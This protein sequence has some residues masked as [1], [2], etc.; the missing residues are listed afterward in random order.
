MKR[1]VSVFLSIIS[2]ICLSFAFTGCENNEAD[3][4]NEVKARIFS[5]DIAY[6]WGWLDEDDLKSIACRQNECYGMDE[7]PYAGAF[8]QSTQMPTKAEKDFKK[9]YCEKYNSNTDKEPISADDVEI[10]YYYGTYGD[11]V[12]VEFNY[13]GLYTGRRIGGIKFSDYHYRAIYVLHYDE[14]RSEDLDITARIYNIEKAYEFG[15]L[16]EDD[17]KSIACYYNEKIGLEENPYSG[18]YVKPE[19]KLSK[20]AK[21]VLK[22]K[23]LDQIINSSTECL[24]DAYVSKYIG[25]FSG[26]IVVEMGDNLVFG[27]IFGDEGA[28]KKIGGVTFKHYSWYKGIYVLHTFG[29]PID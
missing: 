21:A 18:L 9:V 8:T 22:T 25:T 28:S 3:E 2:L 20:K 17:L 24:D 27:D 13:S 7:N 6:K 19:E 15:R 11:N 12:A 29:N 23:Y 26:N 4:S 10:F 16:S 5:I 14:Y 1:F